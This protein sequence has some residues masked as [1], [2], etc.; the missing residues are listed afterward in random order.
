[1]FAMMIVVAALLGFVAGM[2]TFKRSERWR[3]GCGNVLR[4]V[5]CPGHPSPFSARLSRPH[6][7]APSRREREASKPGKGDRR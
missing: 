4:C 6:H 3:P 2:A 1:V 7:P 5:A